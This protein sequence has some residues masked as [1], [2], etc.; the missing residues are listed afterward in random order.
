MN[1]FSKWIAKY[2]RWKR[3]RDVIERHGCVTYCPN[4]KDI[5]NDQSE[6]LGTDGSAATYRC[7]VCGAK[8]TFDFGTPVPVLLTWR[9]Q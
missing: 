1:P 7:K 4:C 5:L 9:K 2:K 3:E 6:M 8:S